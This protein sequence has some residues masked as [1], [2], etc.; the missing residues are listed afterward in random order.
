MRAKAWPLGKVITS[1]GVMIGTWVTA[2]RSS[3]RLVKST[4]VDR[5]ALSVTPETRVMLL[6]STSGN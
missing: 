5:S 1:L 3:L 2:I 6:I 4:P